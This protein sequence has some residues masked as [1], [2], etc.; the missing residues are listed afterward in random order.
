MTAVPGALQALLL[1]FLVA[2]SGCHARSAIPTANEALT[3]GEQGERLLLFGGTALVLALCSQSPTCWLCTCL[4]I[5][6]IVVG[7]YLTAV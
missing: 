7:S 5:Q 1:L 6:P 3:S 2:T 4:P